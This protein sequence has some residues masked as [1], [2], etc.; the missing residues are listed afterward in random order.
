MKEKAI[1]CF[2]SFWKQAWIQDAPIQHLKEKKENDKSG[3]FA[4][5]YCYSAFQSARENKGTGG[6]D[7]ETLCL[8]LTAY[9]ASWG[10]Y[11][12]SSFLKNYNYLVHENV[13]DIVLCDR[14]RCLEGIAL[15]G[16]D[17]DEKMGLLQELYE[18]IAEKAYNKGDIPTD[19]LVSKILLGTMACI[20]A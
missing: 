10:M 11:R 17:D 5:D 20:P 6:Y 16:Y 15:D 14:Y 18:K 7:S 4:W 19:T 12:G 8:H 3:W 1:G 2:I 13:I 9:L